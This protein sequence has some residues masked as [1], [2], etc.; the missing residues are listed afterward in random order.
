MMPDN[1]CHTAQTGIQISFELP[2]G[3]LPVPVQKHL[4]D[5]QMGA[6]VDSED[7]RAAYVT[8]RQLGWGRS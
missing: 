7:I 8:G 6:K 4:C 2:G 5:A 1:S 3:C